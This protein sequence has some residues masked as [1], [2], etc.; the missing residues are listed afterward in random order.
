MPKIYRGMVADGDKPKVG[1]DAQMLGARIPIDIQMD[2]SGKVHPRS[3]GMSVSPS[4]GALP[5]HRIPKRLRPQGAVGARG[6]NSLRVWSMGEGPFDPGPVARGLFLGL[7]SP[8]HAHVE[9]AEVMLVE[10]YQSALSATRDA[11]NIDE[12]MP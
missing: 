5:V 6:S 7:E 9:P 10:E 11:W 3:G 4:L 8:R 12:R 2:S 1:P